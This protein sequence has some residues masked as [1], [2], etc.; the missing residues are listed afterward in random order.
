MI[1]RYS[2]R[3]PGTI[4]TSGRSVFILFVTDGSVVNV[5]FEIFYAFVP[6]GLDS[7]KEVV[8]HNSTLLE[9]YRKRQNV[10]LT[11]KGKEDDDSAGELCNAYTLEPSSPPTPSSSP[12]QCKEEHY[13]GYGILASPNYPGCYPNNADCG[14]SLEA[15]AGQIVS[16]AALEG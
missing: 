4:T 12:Q 8:P 15:P 10:E 3:K 6:A 2:G 5:G 1:G 9:E 13:S 7:S 14:I 11:P 16:F